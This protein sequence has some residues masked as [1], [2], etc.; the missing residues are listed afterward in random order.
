MP[1]EMDTHQRGCFSFC[2]PLPTDVAA[3]AK[4]MAERPRV[5]RKVKSDLNLIGV[6]SSRPIVN[7]FGPG[8]W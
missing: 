1:E 8:G 3:I 5:S 4:R 6:R 2:D 7:H